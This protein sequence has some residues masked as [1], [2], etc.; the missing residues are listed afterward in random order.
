ML[1]TLYNLTPGSSTSPKIPLLLLLIQLSTTM[2]RGDGNDGSF[3]ALHRLA[4]SLLL[5]ISPLLDR[6][7]SPLSQRRALYLAAADALTESGRAADGQN[8][9][10]KYLASFPEGSA[11]TRQRATEAILGGLSDPIGQLLSRSTADHGVSLLSLPPIRDLISHPD[12]APLLRLLDIYSSGSLDDYRALTSETSSAA[13]LKA[14]GIDVQEGERN[15]RLLS[16]CSL[17]A[18]STATIPGNESSGGLSYASVAE[19]LRIREDEVE[20]WIVSAV[21]RGLVD[22]KMD[23][24]EKRVVV[25]RAMVRKFGK[26]QWVDLGNRLRAWREAVK[27]VLDGMAGDAAVEKL[28]ASLVDQ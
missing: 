28:G 6:W 11:E 21:R 3:A 9:L 12:T 26:A 5:Q 16:L 2:G 1:A 7:E 13:V 10:L 24:I 18:E 4:D 27:G 14:H 22:A 20:P 19:A 15:M 23:Q 25:E 17:A 8:F